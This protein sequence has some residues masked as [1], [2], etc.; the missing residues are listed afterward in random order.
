MFGLTNSDPA[1]TIILAGSGRSGTTWLGNIIAASPSMRIIFEPFDYRHVPA[2]SVLPL[3]AYARPTESYPDWA[4]F[5]GQALRGQLDNEWVNRQGRRRWAWQRL[6]KAIR[7]N[8]MLGWIDHT[9]HPKIVFT[10]RH[11]CAVVLSRVKL[12][13]DTHLDVFLG[14]PQLVA[15]YLEPFVEVINRA[16]TPLQQHTV[17]WCIENLVP[18]RQLPDYDWIFCSYEQLYRNPQPEAER[19]LAGLGLRQS[20]FTRRAITKVTMVARPDSAILSNEDP[21]TAW[22]NKLTAQEIDEILGI[23]N[24]FGIDLYSDAALPHL[25]RLT[26]ARPLQAS[27]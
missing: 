4:A 3:R 26:A 17:T 16:Q 20:W 6:V 12:Q 25:D 27:G 22:K 18:L 21:L 19:V 5:V 1:Q 10:I 11:P 7:A 8:L 13:W 2:A 23:V 15:D 24:Q 9:F 14:Q